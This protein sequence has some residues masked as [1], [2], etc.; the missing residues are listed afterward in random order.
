MISLVIMCCLN[1]LS[2]DY[3]GSLHQHEVDSTSG[4]IFE[5]TPSNSR[6]YR[7]ISVSNPLLCHSCKEQIRN[8]D[9]TIKHTTGISL[10]DEVEKIMSKK[11]M[12]NLEK[13][14]S[15][16]YNLKKNYKYN[17]DLN[18][19]F[20]KTILEKFR[21]SIEANLPQWI[22]GTIITGTIGGI[23]AIIGLK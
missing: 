15:P 13:K 19:G 4:C 7:R 18:S 10:Y 14:D 20:H 8:L 5:N 2:Q 1:N 21:D 23:F 6:T 3:N 22:I 11:W 17:L 12:G 16:I 9:G